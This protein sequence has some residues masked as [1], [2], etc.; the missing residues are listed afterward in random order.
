MLLRRL[1][2]DQNIINEYLDELVQVLAEHPVHQ[3]HKYPWGVC[4]SKW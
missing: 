2:V 1:R 4:Q 3:A